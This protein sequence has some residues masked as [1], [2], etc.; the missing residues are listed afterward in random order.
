M[1]DRGDLIIV[2]TRYDPPYQAGLLRGGNAPGQ[3]R[4]SCEGTKVFSRNTLRSAS[5]RNYGKDFRRC[6]YHAVHP[7]SITRFAPVIY[8]EA[9]ERRKTSAPQYSSGFAMRPIGVLSLYRR[10]NSGSWS[11]STPPRVKVF[12]RTFEPAQ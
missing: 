5:S 6:L 11:A 1:G 4:P 9:S 12:T 7:P 3:Q 8:E 10:T 2:R